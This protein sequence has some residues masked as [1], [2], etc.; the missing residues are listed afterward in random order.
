M[1]QHDGADRASANDI[2]TISESARLRSRSRR[3]HAAAQLRAIARRRRRRSST[4]AA[5]LTLTV[6]AAT[7]LAIGQSR[8]AQKA[9]APTG[10]SVVQRGDSGSAVRAVQRALGISAD[11]VFGPATHRAVKRFQ[12]RSGLEVDGIVGPATL[13]ALGISVPA[14]TKR[15]AA[16][17]RVAGDASTI[18]QRIAQCESGGDPTAVSADGTY[19]G[20]YQFRRDTWRSLG[21]K[22]DPAAAP[23]PEQDRLAAKLLAQRGTQPWPVCGA[24]AA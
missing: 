11:G 4:T 6:A 15:T 8:Q 24:K 2:V 19:R 22:G 12:R 13:R 17:P 14:A 3:R 10:A 18:L 5:V 23:E 20:K 21:G 9:D 16:A 1:Q 7:P